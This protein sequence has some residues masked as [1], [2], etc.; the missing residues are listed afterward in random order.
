MY[1]ISFNK[2]IFA[3]SHCLTTPKAIPPYSSEVGW[4]WAKTDS[5]ERVGKYNNG[6]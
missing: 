6:I 3:Q 5:S 4:S 2:L 1:L